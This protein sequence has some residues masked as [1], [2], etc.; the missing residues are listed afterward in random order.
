MPRTLPQ[1]DTDLAR[2]EAQVKRLLELAVEQGRQIAAL[3]QALA[4]NGTTPQ[5]LAQ[6]RDAV[7]D[8]RDL[9]RP[10]AAHAARIVAVQAGA[11]GV[12]D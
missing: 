7:N 3:Q 11:L 12:W 6:I 8:V 5:L 2:A 10:I 1:V 4:A 9:A